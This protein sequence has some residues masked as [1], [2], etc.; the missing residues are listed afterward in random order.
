MKS[1]FP[2]LSAAHLESGISGSSIDSILSSIGSVGFDAWSISGSL[3]PR[4]TSHEDFVLFKSLS[5][6]HSLLLLKVWTHSLFR[7]S[8]YQLARLMSGLLPRVRHERDFELSRITEV[9]FFSS[10]HDSHGDFD[11][12][13]GEFNSLTFHRGLTCLTSL[14]VETLLFNA[15]LGVSIW[16]A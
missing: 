8:C 13:L 14:V 6:V 3:T 1:F 5:L 2:E 16:P 10:P 15:I 9:D 12:L 11:T 7:H 4:G